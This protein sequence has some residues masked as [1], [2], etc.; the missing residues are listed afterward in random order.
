MGNFFKH[1]HTINKHRRGVISNARH[2]GLFWHSLKHDL[3][4]YSCKEFWPS[5]KY[6][7]G[8]DTPIIEERK[9][10]SGFSY[11]CNHHAKRN[12]HH[13][14]FWTDFCNGN[15][16][17]KTMPY[18]YALEMVC[19]M[20][21]ASRVYNGKNFDRSKPINY[22]LK[23]VRHYYMTKASV[24]FVTWCLSTYEKSEWKELNKKNSKTK[25]LEIISRLPDVEIFTDTIHDDD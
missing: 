22:F 21:S 15:I 18:K 13:W 23:K 2:V 7:T 20:I 8:T 19:D 5:V 3:S 1:L 6:Y 24:E 9:V 12:K 10:N 4:K 17:V 14:Q 16:I 25:Y 11:I